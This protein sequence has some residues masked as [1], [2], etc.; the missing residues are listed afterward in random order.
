MN[1]KAFFD[2]FIRGWIPEEPKMPKN[3]LTK[4][5]VPTASY[6]KFTN[7]L[8]IVYAL[9]LGFVA[10]WFLGFL[11]LYYWQD[12]TVN[13]FSNFLYLLPTLFFI[14]T[15]PLSIF[16][17]VFLTK[18]GGVNYFRSWNA[19]KKLQLS[20]Y[21][22]LVGYI[23]VILPQLLNIRVLISPS[24]PY[25]DYMNA[26]LGVYSIFVYFG[27]S[28][29]AI[30][31]GSLFV[32]YKKSA[33]S[34][35]AITASGEGT[36][37]KKPKTTKRTLVLVFVIAVLIVSLVCLAGAHYNLQRKYDYLSE[38]F[39][40]FKRDN[41]RLVNEQWTDNTGNDSKYV[42]FKV[43]VLNIGYGKSYNVTVI[44]LIHGLGNT[45]LERE[46]I[47]VGDL[48]VFQYQELDVNIGYSGELSH[49]S[50]GY[51]MN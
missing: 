30:G 43:G 2:R 26:L 41:I 44:V 27:L 25:Q 45:V 9:T 31:F 15:I 14:N 6:L 47:F 16:A 33:S 24:H 22:I 42:N 23:S 49:V 29:M 17:V 48:D 19:G 32:L 5:H 11:I 38:G 39:E 10:A 7:S 40:F 36:G 18:G 1:F 46:E 28:L 37:V 8:K 3:L 50:T 4:A 20:V 35:K 12:L 34:E 21:A 13:I 51:S